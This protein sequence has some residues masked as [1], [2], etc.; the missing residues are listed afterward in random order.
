MPPSV[1][2][3]QITL[4]GHLTRDALGTAL[5][6]ATSSIAQAPQPVTLIV[7][8]LRMTG[9]DGDVRALFVS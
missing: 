1:P 9:Y 4:A 2:P 6:R 8:C 7:D 3:V 5:D